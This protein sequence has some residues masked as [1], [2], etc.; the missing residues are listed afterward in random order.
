[1]DELDSTP[2]FHARGQLNRRERDVYSGHYLEAELEVSWDHPNQE[3]SGSYVCTVLYTY[4]LQEI[5]SLRTLE[6]SYDYNG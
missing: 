4:K 5:G 1:M 3:Q 6:I 2:G